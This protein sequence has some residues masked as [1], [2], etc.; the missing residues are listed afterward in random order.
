MN[1]EDIIL[2]EI[3]QKYTAATLTSQVSSKCLPHRYS[4]QK[5]SRQETLG[6]ELTPFLLPQTSVKMAW[7]NEAKLQFLK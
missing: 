7:E 2:S 5:F 4:L 1:L 6:G 3:I